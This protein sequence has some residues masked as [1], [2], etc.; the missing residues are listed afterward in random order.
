MVHYFGYI[1]YMFLYSGHPIF[2]A[3]L[4]VV[5]QSVP[6]TLIVSHIIG[7]G[8]TNCGGLNSLCCNGDFPHGPIV[9]LCAGRRHPAV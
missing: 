3:L 1:E 6:P 2:M 7:K 9:V 5:K 8:H 4:T